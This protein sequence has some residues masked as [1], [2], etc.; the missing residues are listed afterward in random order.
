MVATVPPNFTD[1][2]EVMGS[3][4]IRQTNTGRDIQISKIS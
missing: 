4:A 3:G 2:R 1:M